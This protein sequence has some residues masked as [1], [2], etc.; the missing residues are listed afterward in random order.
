VTK[1]HAYLPRNQSIILQL[2]V[3][4]TTAARSESY[5]YNVF[6]Y[7]PNPG[8]REERQALETPTGVFCLGR[9]PTL[10]L[11]TNIPDR[12]SANAEFIMRNFNNSIISSH[13]LY[14][15][16]FQFTRFDAWYPDP[17][18]RSD[19]LHFTDLHDFGTGLSYR[20][21]HSNRQCTYRNISQ[22]S[23][24]AVSVDEDHANLLQMGNPQHLFL[25]DDM[26]FQ[27]TGEKRCRDGV[28]CNVWIGEKVSP[29]NNSIIEH[30]EWYWATSVNGEP[31]TQWIP[32]KLVEKRFV[33]DGALRRA[34]EINLFNYRRNPLTIFEIDYTLSECYR[35]LGPA[36]KFNIGVLSFTIAN[37]KNYS[38]YQNL[39]YLR[40]H[41]WETLVFTMFVRPIRISNIIVD[42]DEKDILVTF[43]LLDVPPV[44]G[45]V[46]FPIKEASLDTSIERLTKVIDSNGLAFRGKNGTRV[47]NLRARAYSL[48]IRH[49]STQQKSKSSGSLIT[50]LWIGLL[51]AGLIIGAIGA[52]IAFGRFAKK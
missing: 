28:W 34:T 3:T 23:G 24:D 45:P 10:P 26:N 20:Y 40:F 44:T 43:T 18:G 48:N 49:R 7:S 1:F 2:D 27:Y 46:E 16:E 41:I 42:T 37:D 8:R 11:P 30:R 31:L 15:T 12:V 29:L 22:N 13:N 14:D 35:A 9:T 21:N 6:R 4:A 32:M 36:E 17:Q 33:R 47:V 39:N 51:F 38:V 19:W 25:M 50:G 5:S 52:F